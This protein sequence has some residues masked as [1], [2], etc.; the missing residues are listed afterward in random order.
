MTNYISICKSF[1][2]YN[3]MYLKS[4]NKVNS[5]VCSCNDFG[6]LEIVC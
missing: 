5:Y 6:I 1:D 3:D 2:L 4:V